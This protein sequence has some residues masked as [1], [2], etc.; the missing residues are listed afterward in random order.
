MHDLFK[1]NI[2]SVV[3]KALVIVLILCFAMTIVAAPIVFSDT[4]PRYYKWVAPSSIRISTERKYTLWIDA[5]AGFQIQ[6][7]N[8]ETGDYAGFVTSGGE[9]S[10]DYSLSGGTYAIVVDSGDIPGTFECGL[11]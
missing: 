10:S 5:P 9:A 2:K 3:Q 8:E 7:V 4:I 1:R 6:I 11:E